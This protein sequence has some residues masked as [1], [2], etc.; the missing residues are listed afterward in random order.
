MMQT[1]AGAVPVTAQDWNELWKARQT[2]RTSPHDAAYWDRR[3]PSFGQKDTPDAYAREFLDLAG[4]QPGEA[5]LDMGCGTGNLSVPLGRAGHRV[6]AADFSPVMLERLQENLEADHITSVEPLL[7]SWEDDWAAAGV[8]PGGFDV[9]VA[10]RSIATDDLRGALMKLTGAARRRVCITLATGVS[11]RIDGALMAQLG[12]QV[13]QTM[14]AAY[15]IAILSAEGFRPQLT[16]IRTT[17]QD[18]FATFEDGMG[19]FTAMADAAL[20]EAA[21]AP[22]RAEALGRLEAWLRENLVPCGDGVRLRHPRAVDW[23]FIWWDT[24]FC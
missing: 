10:S 21:Q 15:A 23:A 17:R 2:L 14:D 19:H 9:C 20:A 22:P 8:Q 6:L 24:S 3:A 4:V 1:Q 16:Y 12:I 18:A 11:P 5:V 13:P 7:L